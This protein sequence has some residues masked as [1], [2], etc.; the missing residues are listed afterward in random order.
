MRPYVDMRARL[1]RWWGWLW[2]TT[3]GLLLLVS[4]RYFEVI[5]LD[6]RPASMLFR[7]SM[8]VAHF[9]TFAAVSL[10][11]ALALVVAWPRPRI[12][13]PLGVLCGAAAVAIV[14]IDTQVYQLYRF[15]INAGVLNLL[16]G[17]AAGETFVFSAAMYAQAALIAAAI[18]AVFGVASSWFWRRVS[19]PAQRSPL[20]MII[21]GVATCALLTFHSIH[22][23][24]DAASYE[25]FLEQT[26]VL[27]M[28]YA[29]TAK[30]LLRAQGVNLNKLQ[31]AD[32]D[33][34]QANRQL[35]YPLQ[36]LSCRPP[37]KPPNIVVIAIDSWRFD[38][39]DARVTPNIERFAQRSV[40][41]MDHYSGGNA[42]RIGMFSLFYSIPGT[43]WHRALA[44]RRGPVLIDQLARL[45][46]DV[47]VFRSAPLYSPEFDRTVFSQV[48]AVRMRSEGASPDA[49]DRDLTNDFLAYLG[50]REQTAPFF[51]LLF[52]DA[53]HSFAY[54]DDYPAPFAPAAPHVNYLQLD[55]DTDPLPLLNRYRNSV[56]YVDSLVGEAIA[57]LESR[58]LLENS[59][60]IITSDH[61]QE[62]NDNG[63]NYW[64]HASN[65]TRFQTA[66]PMSLY[67][68]G[69]EPRVFHHRTTHFDVMPTVLRDYLGCD[70]PFPA[71]SVGQPLDEP[72]GREIIVM[73][74]YADFAIKHG[75]QI[76]VVRKHGM[77]IRDE[78][79]LELDTR[80]A[81][82]VIAGALEQKA[83]FVSGDLRP[84]Q[85]P[86][87]GVGHGAG[88][89]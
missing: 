77:E 54:P 85:R 87:E 66:V 46:Y 57:G 23:W 35:T 84:L 74:E 27:P 44:E 73:S 7:A 53:P 86:G 56:H 15:H 62:F 48:E 1:M 34:A 83:R 60:V 12:A 71:Y 78:D 37:E 64:G 67:A 82:D 52:Y 43:Y 88:T 69:L 50:E 11:P 16:F 72:G 42:T 63:Q 80:L 75:N 47:Q 9:T 32:T 61:G 68:P 5:D 25:P 20:P 51:A 38:A 36:P 81:P 26:E 8:L 19:G 10:L 89:H 29:A 24:A 41:F 70:T 40:R 39:L 4:L 49:W 6:A 55:R 33:V 21:T 58:G 2:L 45:H 22:I 14:L 13:I 79:H 65:F 59:V 28:R 31:V 30:R 18:L 3:L 76:A 17:G